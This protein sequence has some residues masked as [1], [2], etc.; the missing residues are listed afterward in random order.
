MVSRLSGRK[1]ILSGLGA[2]TQNKR[3]SKIFAFLSATFPIRVGVGPKNRLSGVC[4]S[5]A[6]AFISKKKCVF[7]RKPVDHTASQ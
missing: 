2:G 3:I 1:A 5:V 4:E 7:K 6:Q